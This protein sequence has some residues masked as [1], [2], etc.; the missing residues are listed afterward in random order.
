[1]VLCKI[2]IHWWKKSCTFS[3]FVLYLSMKKNKAEHSNLAK[4]W[5]AKDDDIRKHT[6]ENT[7]SRPSLLSQFQFL[8]W[9]YA[10]NLPTN[11]LTA[12]DLFFYKIV[13]THLL[14]THTRKSKPINQILKSI[15]TTLRKLATGTRYICRFR[16]LKL[17]IKAYYLAKLITRRLNKT[18]SRKYKTFLFL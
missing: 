1:M 12:V 4:S 16:K 18:T 15:T 11:D 3:Y 17:Y 2:N 5:C 6:Q 9:T 13:S 10:H 7:L 14:H 8:L